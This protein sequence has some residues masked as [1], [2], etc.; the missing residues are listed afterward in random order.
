M[1]K[2]LLHQYKSN[3]RVK[4]VIGLFSVN[5]I[6]LPIGIV[7]SIV[8][9]KYLGLQGY[10]DFKFI[11]SIFS[12]A[13]II[14]SFGFFQAGN[15]ALVLNNDKQKAKE[16]YGAELVITG[17][18]FIIMTVS[19]VLYAKIDTN[20][21]EKNLSNFLLFIIPFGWVFLLQR[22]FEN[23]FQADNRIKMLSQFRLYPS[24][25][26]LA[27]ATLIYFVLMEKQMNK[28]AVIWIFNL[29]TQ[30]I[31]YLFILFK[32]Q[33]SFKN[34]RIRL[35]EI[36]N[37]NKSYGFNVYLG[38]LFAI[39]FSSL[40][41]LL[42]SYFGI[43][44][45]GVG[46]YSLALTFTMPLSLIPNTIATTHYKDFSE[47]NRVPR[48]LFLITAGLS[49]IALLGIW[50]LVGPFIKIFYGNE[51]ENVIPLNFI[52]SFGVTAHGFAD[53]F[54][55][56]LGANGQGMALRNSAFFVGASILIF[57][58]ILIPKYGEYGA[59]YTKLISGFVYLFIIILYYLKFIKNAK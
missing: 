58:L 51:F 36:W 50:L 26:F 32:L 44:N 6:A 56:Y 23:L 24:V 5:I 34:I 25:G 18:I 3:H 7:T 33:V 30:V 2:R 59:A 21:N 41:E 28:L 43:D 54:N 19:L 55:R 12:I 20:I 45:S 40:T 1:I 17:G 52:M 57:S 9:T 46:L 13:V 39:G 38:S 37:F 53:F 16:F 11:N 42:I 35:F 49:I 22:Y 8:I 31:V 27:A 29:A 15:R 48:K 4:Q 10:G 14:F 47:A